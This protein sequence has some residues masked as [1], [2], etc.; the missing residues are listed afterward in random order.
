M[1]SA[2]AILAALVMTF[3]GSV[4]LGQS[5]A[6]PAIRAGNY[7]IS[8]RSAEDIMLP[9]PYLLDETFFKWPKGRPIGSISAIDMDRDGKSIWV[10]ERCGTINSCIGSTVNPIM[11]FDETGNLVKEFGAGL[12][13]YPH[14]IYVDFENNIWVTDLQSNV[15]RA[16]GLTGEKPAAAPPG[17][18]LA[19]AVVRKFSP[20]GKL[21][22]TL[23]TPGVMG[24]DKAHFSQPSDVAV[25]RNGDIFVADG[26]DT[27]P[28]NHRIVK[29]DRE[30]R[31]IKEWFACG[32]HPQD[33]LDCQHSIAIDSQGRL[34]VA[35]RG[36]NRIEIFDQEG[37]LLDELYT[38]GRSSGLFIDD[39]DILYSADSESD[40]MQH[41][42]YVRG[43]HVGN[44]RTGEVTAFLPD[45]QGNPAPW[46]PAGATNGAEGVAVAKDGT[47][48]VSKVLPAQL[49]RYVRKDAESR[50]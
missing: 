15:D 31:Y 42:A 44:A 13:V 14:G 28:S 27:Q 49:V 41:N 35:N 17:T 24:S 4:A 50:R 45:P 21:L 1:R 11:K 29:F 38:F 40:V 30:G 20:D 9:N 26:H 8:A 33:T 12:F 5:M 19:G 18:P 47:I 43:V 32:T 39:N 16:A 6:Q 36:N 7:N 48:Y 2:P 10:F 34:F 3:G 22:M 37:K 23:G 46:M 25:A